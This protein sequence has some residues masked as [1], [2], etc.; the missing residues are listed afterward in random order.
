MSQIEN[1][2]QV[3]D[4]SNISSD[5]NFVHTFGVFSDIF[6]NY[7]QLCPIVMRLACAGNV[8]HHSLRAQGS[9]SIMVNV[10]RLKFVCLCFVASWAWLSG[11]IGE[12]RVLPPIPHIAAVVRLE[13]G[14]EVY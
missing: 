8:L 1:Y 3:F 13:L 5:C 2:Y 6:H 4:S 7:T 12:K 14:L 9:C 11:S 10:A